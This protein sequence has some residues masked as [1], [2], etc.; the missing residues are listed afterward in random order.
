VLIFYTCTLAD[1]I[2][3]SHAS[4]RKRT[5]AKLFVADS[6]PEAS[7]SASLSHRCIS[8]KSMSGIA[9]AEDTADY[10]PVMPTCACKIQGRTLSPFGL[11]FKI[12]EL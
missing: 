6:L 8:F 4:I 7:L 11:C 3:G 2:V 1:S 9:S 12:Y 10:G 5:R